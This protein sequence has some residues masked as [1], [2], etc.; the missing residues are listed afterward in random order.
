MDKLYTPEEY[1]NLQR[2]QQELRDI[3]IETTPF[4]RKSP[5][6]NVIKNILAFSKALEVKK[7]NSLPDYEQILN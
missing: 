2:L 7:L 1:S 4:P 3:E 5:K 6:E